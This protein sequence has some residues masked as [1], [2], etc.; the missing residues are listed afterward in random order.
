MEKALTACRKPVLA[1]PTSYDNVPPDH[2]KNMAGDGAPRQASEHAGNSPK[3][4]KVH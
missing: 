1:V 3:G 2:A 4:K